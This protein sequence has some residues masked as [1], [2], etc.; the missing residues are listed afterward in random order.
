MATEA[1]LALT[2]KP[3]LD[4]TVALRID[5]GTVKKIDVIARKQNRSRSDV[6][7]TALELVFGKS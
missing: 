5:V 1:K 3:D 2:R 4:T 7:R 6:I